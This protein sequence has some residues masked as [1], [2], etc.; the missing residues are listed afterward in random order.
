MAAAHSKRST[1]SA[2]TRALTRLVL[3]VPSS[4]ERQASDPTSQSRRLRTLASRKAAGI[5]AG[6]ALPPGPLGLLTILPDLAAIWRVQSALVADIASVYGKTAFLTRETMA[7]CLFKH[8]GAALFR[9]V[10]ARAGERFVMRPATLRFTQALLAKIGVRVT[11]RAIGS[12]ALRW[13][14]LVGAAGVG[15]YA[16]LDTKKVG[17][18]AIELFAA[19]I[20]VVTNDGINNN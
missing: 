10:V 16:Y 19:D 14:P 18:N 6:L 12:A 1:A 3:K 7:Y 4:N 11:E 17:D 15:A 5:S 13:I 20:N 2:V 9:D 8:G